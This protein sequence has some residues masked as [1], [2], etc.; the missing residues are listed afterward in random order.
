[1]EGHLLGK[2]VSLQFVCPGGKTGQ[3]VPLARESLGAYDPE[4]R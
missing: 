2:S 1:M 3:Q 4:L